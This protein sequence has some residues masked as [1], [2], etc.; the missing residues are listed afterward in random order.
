VCNGLRDIA[1]NCPMSRM[2]HSSGKKYY[3][4]ESPFNSRNRFI[5]ANPDVSRKICGFFLLPEASP[6]LYYLNLSKNHKSIESIKRSVFRAEFNSFLYSRY[7]LFN[8]FAIRMAPVE[9]WAGYNKNT[10]FIS[11]D[12][13]GDMNCLHHSII[14][15]GGKVQDLKYRTIG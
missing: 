13:Y 1:W 2:S 10:V 7:S 8:C 9:L 6:T 14:V 15:L 3:G 11:L 5:A 12:K 4:L